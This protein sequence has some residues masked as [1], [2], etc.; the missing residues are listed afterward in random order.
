VKIAK[1]IYYS[2]KYLYKKEKLKTSTIQSLPFRG[3]LEG[4]ANDKL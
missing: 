3:D 1:D 2:K 4:F